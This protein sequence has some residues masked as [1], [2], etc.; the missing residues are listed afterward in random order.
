MALAGHHGH[1]GPCA[2]C[3]LEHAAR[4]LFHKWP[5]VCRVLSA[6]DKNLTG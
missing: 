1:P 4:Q 6:L 2:L 3:V 5:K